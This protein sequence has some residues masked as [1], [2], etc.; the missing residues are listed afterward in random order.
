[1][2]SQTTKLKAI[3]SPTPILPVRSF[4]FLTKLY[5][6]GYAIYVI[7]LFN[8][9]FDKA[10]DWYALG[11]V[12][13]GL[14]CLRSRHIDALW[15][16]FKSTPALK[17]FGL[18]LLGLVLAL[19]AATFRQ[20]PQ[21]S[22]LLSLGAQCWVPL[23]LSIITASILM[24]T[25]NANTF[26][27][28]IFSLGA[29]TI[30]GFDIGLYSQQWS[31][32]IPMDVGNSHRDLADAYTFFLPFVWTLAIFAK[33]KFYRVLL[34]IL[35]I[36]IGMLSV[37][38]GS[39]G[40]YI[41]LFFEWLILMLISAFGVFL[42]KNNN[43][44]KRLIS[45]TKLT[46]IGAIL[47]LALWATVHWLSPDLFY[48][49]LSRGLQVDDR[50]L[51]TW[52]PT[53]LFISNEPWFG[54]GFGP[55]IWNAVYSA[56]QIQLPGAINFGGA[57]NWLLQLGFLGGIFAIAFT[58]CL[59]VGVFWQLRLILDNIQIDLPIQNAALAL[60]LSFFTFYLVRGLVE[61]PNWKPFYLL[62][63]YLLYLSWKY[64]SSLQK[65]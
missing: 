38:A 52:K 56:H 41:A 34:W 25:K 61:T 50:M 33:S 19:S 23:A 47:G 3:I 15:N 31:S 13:Y 22:G 45:F 11:L 39:R 35:I 5:L 30:A 20:L 9:K 63:T 8:V 1:M 55:S 42:K 48:G 27:L 12:F 57:H 4:S 2:S 49:A 64:K 65:K 6:L 14:C 37:G 26:L 16:T 43:E 54:Y 18:S 53:I 36:L 29:A 51:S 62:M 10:L 28:T 24:S 32:P 44:D 7:L 21:T 58:L 40:V 46:A 17:V 59:I 60:G